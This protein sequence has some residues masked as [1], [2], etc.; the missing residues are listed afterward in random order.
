MRE[1]ERVT[2]KRKCI[3][4]KG[5]LFFFN[6]PL[7]LIFHCEEHLECNLYLAVRFLW[8]SL[9]AE[10]LYIHFAKSSCACRW[11]I[12]FSMAPFWIPIKNLP[13]LEKHGRRTNYHVMMI[14][15]WIATLF[16]S[17][18]FVHD[19]TAPEWL[20]KETLPTLYIAYIYIYKPHRSFCVSV[21]SRRY[22][23]ILCRNSVLCVMHLRFAFISL[24]Y[25]YTHF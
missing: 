14:C 7:Y 10:M 25:Y 4:L 5:V 6:Y 24:L 17:T 16:P 22:K 3:P 20:T 13:T 19:L 21:F 1:R 11:I 8:K 9:M 18:V 23:F 15:L 2:K 12:A